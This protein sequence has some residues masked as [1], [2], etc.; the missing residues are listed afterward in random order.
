MFNVT[1]SVNISFKEPIPEAVLIGCL[2]DGNCDQKWKSHLETFF[3]EIATHDIIS[4]ANANSVPLE[5]I[6]AFYQAHVKPKITNK[7]LEEA[8]KL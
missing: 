6:W 3:T 8:F 7:E 2:I 5:S 4:F 1:A